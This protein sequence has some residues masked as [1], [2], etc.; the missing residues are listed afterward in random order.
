[1]IDAL[2]DPSTV[3]PVKGMQTVIYVKPTLKNKNIT[4]GD[5]TYFSDTDFESHVT[6]HYDFCGDKLI[7][8]NFCQIAK[9]VEF[10]MNGANHRMNTISTFPFYIFENWDQSVPPLEEMPLKGD[11]IVGNDVWIGQ[12]A[13]ILPGAKIGDGVIIGANS[14]VGGTV[15]PY[16]IVVGNP[17]KT[18]KKRFDDEL[19]E[20]MLK[21][22][23]WFFP[24][25]KIKELV[26]LL[27][28][29]NLD[30]VKKKLRNIV[31]LEK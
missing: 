28:D 8:G 6:H 30:G 18:I 10:I 22:R 12:N 23:W 4:V 3:F 17:A 16:S 5:F 13:T 29:S 15:E 20:L 2:P 7:I 19:I 21:F 11:T 31:N 24:I 25:K 9:G 26:P 1:M 14:M 27:S